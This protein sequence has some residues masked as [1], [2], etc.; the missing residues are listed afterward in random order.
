MSGLQRM[1]WIAVFSAGDETSSTLTM[2]WPT[3]AMHSRPVQRPLEKHGHLEWLVALTARYM[4]LSKAMTLSAQLDPTILCT[5]VEDWSSKSKK[6]CSM[7]VER[8][9]DQF[10]PVIVGHAHTQSWGCWL[11][12]LNQSMRY[13]FCTSARKSLNVRCRGHS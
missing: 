11:N 13:C 6:T 5:C 10:C 8:V 2:F 7:H 9:F 4:V 1:P 12:Q 3:K